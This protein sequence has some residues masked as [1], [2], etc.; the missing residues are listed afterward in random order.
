MN[1]LLLIASVI[2]GTAKNTFTNYFA[3]AN[4]CTETELNFFNAVLFLVGTVIFLLYGNIS[5]SIYTVFMSVIFAAINLISQISF[6]KSLE[7]GSMSLTTLFSS[8]GMIISAMFG[9]LFRSEPFR[10]TQI[11]GMIFIILAATAISNERSENKPSKKW[12]A[13]VSLSF[14]AS[15]FIGVVQKIHQ[16]SA[17]K[18]EINGF[19]A[20]S[21][22]IMTIVSFAVFAKGKISNGKPLA[23]AQSKTNIIITSVLTGISLAFLHKG[24]LYLS[25][26]LPGMLFFPFH[27]GGVIVLSAICSAVLFREKLGKS[28]LIGISA[29]ILGVIL[30]SI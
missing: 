27:N 30:L 17:Y 25:G 21:F 14:L 6:M 16:T 19:L 9:V 2:I 24:N 3:S 29:G 28:K 4:K 20:I 5:V 15:G 1:Y 11:A 8:C 22:G 18:S 13:C 7:Y 23:F 12:V 26:V 10:I